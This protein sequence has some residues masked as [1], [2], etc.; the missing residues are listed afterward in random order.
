MIA[1][2]VH[3]HVRAV[4]HPAPALVEFHEHRSLPMCCAIHC[5]CHV[6]F[7]GLAWGLW[8]LPQHQVPNHQLRGHLVQ[9]HLV[10]GL[11]HLFH[12]RLAPQVWQ[13]WIPSV[14]E[15]EPLVRPVHRFVAS[16]LEDREGLLKVG[17][18]VLGLF[19]DRLDRPHPSLCCP[20]ALWVV[21]GRQVEADAVA[22]SEVVEGLG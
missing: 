15:E 3:L 21:C 1:C 11:H 12:I 16:V 4:E 9:S 13:L 10:P 18:L 6:P 8:L 19:H 17:T 14:P 2:G 7:L 22:V 5:P 20:R